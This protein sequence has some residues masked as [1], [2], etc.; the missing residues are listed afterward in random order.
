MTLVGCSEKVFYEPQLT[1]HMMVHPR[2]YKKHHLVLWI[3]SP[4]SPMKIGKYPPQ[5]YLCY[6]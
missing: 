5:I 6:L 3:F 2:H 4:E 1:H